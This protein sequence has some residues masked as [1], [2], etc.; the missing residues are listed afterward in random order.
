MRPGNHLSRARIV[1]APIALLVVAACFLFAQSLRSQLYEQRSHSLSQTTEKIVQLMDK[2][3]DNEWDRL[4]YVS[5]ELGRAPQA[6]RAELLARMEDFYHVDPRPH[7]WKISCIDSS[8]NVYRWDGRIDRWTKPDMLVEGHP[9]FQV[10]IL[11][12]RGNHDE[13]MIFLYCLPEPIRLTE[14]DIVI[15]HTLLALDMATFGETLEVSAFEGNS[16]FYIV[17][18][19]GTRIYHQQEQSKFIAAYNI[20]AALQ[21]YE[22]LYGETYA[23]LSQSISGGSPYTAE[24]QREGQKYFLSCYPLSVNSWSLF[25]FVPEANVGGNT[26]DLVSLLLVEVGA[27]ALLLIAMI[28]VFVWSN[29][30]QTLARQQAAVDEARRTSQAKSDFLSHMSHDMRTPL[31]GIMGMCHIAEQRLEDNAAVK[32]CLEKINLSS[33]QLLALINDVLDMSRIEHGKV[34]VHQAPTDLNELLRTCAV[35]VEG[36]VLENSIV[37]EQD[38]AGL[39]HPIVSADPVLLDKILTN[40]LGNAAKFTPP[41]GRISLRASEKEVNSDKSVY[42]FEIED[43]GVGMKPEFLGHLFEPF[44]QDGGEG[45]TNYQGTGLGLSIVKNLVDK[46]GG[47]IDVQ[48]AVGKGSKFTVSLP[49][50]RLNETGIPVKEDAAHQAFDG[51]GLRVLLVED[52]ELNRE[53][54]L[55]ILEDCGLSVDTAEDGSIAVECFQASSPGGYDLILM[56][57]RMPVMD[58]LEASRRIRAL[59]RADAAAVPII[60]LT[61]DAFTG[62]ME[63]TR[64][65][66]M[67]EHL[68]KPI[69]LDKLYAVLRKYCSGTKKM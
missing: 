63:K 47:E 31:N 39:R 49:L 68:G 22:F 1:M 54:A 29:A 36:R 64:Q 28:A 35:H 44:S 53:I 15:T 11:E 67:N 56:D 24:I 33:R 7:S 34:E 9:E 25:L 14:E 26:A 18:Q 40:I 59:P 58:G 60:A 62:D 66:G 55:T 17:E 51:S 42:L 32:D 69:E 16:F 20:L 57:V 6:D 23:G 48:S 12:S 27:I 38:T 19:N 50:P 8:G 37:F 52:N 43:T 10:T 61:A 4:V 65:A 5:H 21:N 41:G 13:Q 46:L 30:R 3:I 2:T 45:R